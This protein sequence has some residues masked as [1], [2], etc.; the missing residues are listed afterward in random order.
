[1][2]KILLLL[3]IT[4]FFLDA[5]LVHGKNPTENRYYSIQMMALPLSQKKDGFTIYNKLKEKGYLVYYYKIKIKDIWWMRLKVGLFP[6]IATAQ[7]F[8]K[9]FSRKEGF[10]FFVTRAPVDINAFNN[11]YEIVTTPSAIWLR[12]ESVS[13]EIF[14][15]S[16]SNVE[17]TEVLAHTR[18]EISPDG[19]NIIFH[20]D[21]KINT[22]P[23]NSENVFAKGSSGPDATARQHSQQMADNEIDRAIYELDRAIKT[24]PK[25]AEAY[26]NRG[27]LYRR[28]GI[29][30]R[31]IADYSTAIG[32][33]PER[34]E[35]YTNRGVVYGRKGRYDL[36]ISDYS[37]A[38]ELDAHA[39]DAYNNRGAAYLNK[40]QYDDA[41]SDFNKAVELNPKFSMAYNNRGTTYGIS[42]RHDQAIADFNKAIEIN[43]S[44]ASAYGHRSI[45][46]FYMN[47][48][49]KAWLDVKKAQ[50]LGYRFSPKF[51]KALREASDGKE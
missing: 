11:E 30:D 8:G 10:D 15:F 34:A 27:N 48:F 46:Y 31:A 17:T 47:V 51:L 49:D 7:E 21:G 2:K 50:A 20:L 6:S 18:P 16:R 41:I 23:V 39:A 3:L 14:L 1:M 40:K 22:I 33:N 26:Y 44:D 29:D 25:N 32:I 24:D 38:I 37:K 43:P 12:K 45:A 19:N 13:K 5:T 9:T 42:G 36:A 28:K 4:H 35:I